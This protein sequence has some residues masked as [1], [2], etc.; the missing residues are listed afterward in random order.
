MMRIFCAVRHSNDPRYYYGG[1]WS[2]NFYPALRQL[3]HEI[4][5][6]K[7]DLLPT[8]KLLSKFWTKFGRLIGSSH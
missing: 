7:T 4:L 1:L 8:S 5:E 2:G 6:S 3:S